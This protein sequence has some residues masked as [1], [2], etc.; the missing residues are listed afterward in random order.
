MGLFGAISVTPTTFFLPAL[1]WLRWARPA[2]WSASWCLN[3]ALLVVTAVVGVMG[4]IGSVYSIA[5]NA[6][7]FHAIAM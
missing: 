7:S 3:W 6:R 4:A 2:R 5:Q 1:L